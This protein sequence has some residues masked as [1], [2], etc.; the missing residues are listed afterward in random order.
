LKQRIILV[1][2]SEEPSG[3][4]EHMLTLGSGLAD[5][6]DV[7]LAA[8]D[9]EAGTSLLHRAAASGLGVKALDLLNPRQVRGWLADQA[10]T[11]LH[12]H[13]GIGWE[14]HDLVRYGKAA[15]LAIVRTEHLPYL[16]TSPIQQAAY[17]AM[18]LSVDGRIAVS[19]AVYDS[20]KDRSSARLVLI[21]NG[22]THRPPTVSRE[23]M[24]Q[25]LA[26]A[27]DDRLLLTVARLSPQKGHAVLVDAAPAILARF[28]NA[29]FVLVG[30]G[31]ERDKISASIS[32]AGLQQNVVMLGHRTD[33]PDLLAAADLFILPSLFEGL[34]LALLE[35]MASKL[36]VVATTA[37]GSIEAIGSDHPYLATQ[38]DAASLGDAIIAALDQPDQAKA[39]GDKAFRRYNERF[40]T[41][42][43]AAETA[44]FYQSILHK[45]GARGTNS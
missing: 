14:G 42:R 32:Q 33:V 41:A 40:S 19:Q 18:L 23:Q 13:A 37:G 44:N 43:M 36:P 45:Q 22:V 35:A 5:T 30:T 12:V 34:P 26:V 38:G 25:A 16:L 4:G 21:H 8:P 20:H 6:Y 7:V 17:R 39:E 10:P 24:R 11:L 28:A 2:D 15:G 27:P 9:H 31:P 3:V 1:T 29:K